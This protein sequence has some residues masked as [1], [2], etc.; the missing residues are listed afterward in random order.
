MSSKNIERL[1]DDRTGAG[2]QALPFA[3]AMRAG[4]FV[5]ISGQVAMKENGE[6]E[7]VVYKPL[8]YDQAARTI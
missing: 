5:F 7:A 2:G 1:G 4:D 8:G 3:P 6:I